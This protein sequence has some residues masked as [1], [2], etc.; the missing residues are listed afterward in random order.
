M[1]NYFT[2]NI[3]TAEEEIFSG[4]ACKLFA[5]GIQ[6]E[7]EILYNH[8]SLLTGLV[9]GT[10]WFEDKQGREEGLVVLG[11]ILEVQPKI[12]TILADS[13]LRAKDIDEAAAIE[14]KKN[15]ERVISQR[16]SNLDYGQVRFQLASAVAQLRLI[17]RIK[18]KGR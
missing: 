12:T 18:K 9:P 13:S 6:G 1:T 4:L 17:S 16:E 11:G 5:N 2:L 8:A 14:A 10:V 3:V 7:L 15:M